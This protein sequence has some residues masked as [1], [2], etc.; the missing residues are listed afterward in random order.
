MDIEKIQ[1]EL[2]RKFAEPLPD[3]YKRRI[4]FWI[5]EDGEFEDNIGELQLV[6]AKLLVLTGSNTFSV[7][8]E[9]CY[10][11]LSSNYLI[12]RPFA[13]SNEENWLLNVEFYSGEIFRTDRLSMW[14]DEMNIISTA[15]TRRVVK[16]Y[17]KFFN[18]EKRR[19]KIACLLAGRLNVKAPDIHLAVLS[20]ICG[21]NKINI[22]EIIRQVLRSGLDIATNKICQDI[23][24]YR[25][26]TAF[27]RLVAQRF[28]YEE[29]GKSLERLSAHIVITAASMTMKKD[30][31]IGLD[32]YINEIYQ[33]T[34]YDFVSDWMLSK[35]ID[36]YRNIAY[37]VEKEIHLKKRLERCDIKDMSTIGMFP[38]VDECIL[39]MLMKDIMNNII[40]APLIKSIKGERQCF[41]WYTEFACY[42]QGLE[43]VANMKQFY[44]ENLENFYIVGAEKIWKEYEQRLYKMDTYY[45]DFHLV[46]T[47][48]LSA[49]NLEL[50][51][52][53]KHTADIVEGLYKNWYLE[54]LSENWSNEI[55]EDFKGFGSVPSI[56]K[57]SDFY[58]NNISYTDGRTFVIISDALRYEVGVQLAG[59][60]KR[61]SQARV[62]LTSMQ[63]TFPTITQ[64]GMAALLPHNNLTMSHKKGGG[65]SVLA[66]GTPTE[67]NYR[68]QIL[69]K[70]NKNSICL[71]HNSLI[72]LKRPERSAMVKG[73][74]VVYIYHDT[75]DESSH[76]SDSGV[77]KACKTAIDEI[78]SLV[79]M[80]VNDF[81]GV[82]VIITADHGFLYTYNLLNESNKV[83]VN[84]GTAEIDIGRRYAILSDVVVPEKLMPIKLIDSDMSCM[85]YTPKENIR[86]KRKGSGENFVHGGVSLQEMVVPVITYNHLRNTSKEYLKNKAKYDTTLVEVGLVSSSRKISNMIFA[87][88]FFQKEQVSDVKTESSYTVYFANA[89]GL[90]IS[91]SQ[92][93]IASK[94]SEDTRERSFRCTFN[95]KAMNFNRLET[96]YL[97]IIEDTGVLSPQREE[98][99]ID[100]AFN[101]GEFDFKMD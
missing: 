51:D 50:D 56:A 34:C 45:R 59:E 70:R 24:N 41:A 39:S 26:D 96:Y 67:S 46:F 43:Q 81:S 94:T 71:Q 20:V 18:S 92:K 69:Q 82:R 31:L 74:E 5:D 4:I 1:F 68:E 21:I 97:M 36:T 35:D 40:D 73:K 64:F 53:F 19:T 13:I 44:L 84:Y 2:N 80:I 22:N 15:E 17:S 72:K 10:D 7:K 91:D 76:A 38:S 55:K 9:I 77:F 3:F 100:L 57:Q 79:R 25:A 85:G 101:V 66:D 63:A 95:L 32:R 27:W 11:N 99:N 30:L 28:G 47:E 86:I 98:F 14:L 61:E 54:K 48:S 33:P 87:L 93:I 23:K 78:K 52:L 29:E 65:V 49:S 58:N 8:R 16:K 12:Y 6:D 83:S 62:N 90:Q 60:L 37:F 89:E 75:I 88:N 42:Y